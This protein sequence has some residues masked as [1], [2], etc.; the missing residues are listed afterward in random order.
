MAAYS[1]AK[2]LEETEEDAKWAVNA[3]F[4]VRIGGTFWRENDIS[5]AGDAFRVALARRED[6]RG[7]IW[8]SRRL[9]W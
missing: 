5:G 9:G 1:S 4:C 7:R 8:T 3:D 2:G 6:P